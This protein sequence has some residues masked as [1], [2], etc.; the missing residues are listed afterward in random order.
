MCCQGFTCT[1]LRMLFSVTAIPGLDHSVQTPFREK[2]EDQRH[3]TVVIILLHILL[4][5][6]ETPVRQW[7]VSEQDSIVQCSGYHRSIQ[8]HLPSLHLLQ[9]GDEVVVQ[10]PGRRRWVRMTTHLPDG[11]Q[12]LTRRVAQSPL[13]QHKPERP[14]QERAFLFPSPACQ[15]W[16]APRHSQGCVCMKTRH[17]SPAPPQNHTSIARSSS[18]LL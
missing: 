13:S 9:P 18:P 4:D 15:N 10:T 11:R 8:G 14:S 3:M 17:S 1:H 16:P 6:T 12:L 7:E 2:R 5:S